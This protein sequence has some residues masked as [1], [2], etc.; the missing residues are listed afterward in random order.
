MAVGGTC[1]GNL[2][3][4]VAGQEF[5]TGLQAARLEGSYMLAVIARYLET[6]KVVPGA[7]QAPPLPNSNPPVT[8]V[9]RYNFIPNPPV[10]R[11]TVN[12]IKLWG[13]TVKQLCTY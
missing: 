13:F 1:H 3:P 12:K 8:T 5:G 10:Y 2:K 7:F 6:K 4:L 11:N 9:H